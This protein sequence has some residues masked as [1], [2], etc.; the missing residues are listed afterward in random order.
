MI[1]MT[2]QSLFFLQTWSFRDISN[3]RAP[4]S[5]SW[6][7]FPTRYWALIG[8]DKNA[9]GFILCNECSPDPGLPEMELAL[10]GRV[11]DV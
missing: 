9:A 5:A 7:S 2:G 10:Q 1:P 8:N 6:T 11:R 3:L 4:A